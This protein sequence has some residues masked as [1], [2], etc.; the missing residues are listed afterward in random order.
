MDNQNKLVVYKRDRKDEVLRII[1]TLVVDM[2]SEFTE[3]RVKLD[4]IDTVRPLVRSA[5]QINSYLNEYDAIMAR[6]TKGQ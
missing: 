1:G 3:N 6:E 4:Q 2:E 5:A